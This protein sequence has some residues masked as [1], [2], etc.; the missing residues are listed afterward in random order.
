MGL[1]PR[2]ESTQKAPQKISYSNPNTRGGYRRPRTP[3]AS[4]ALDRPAA[5]KP[6]PFLSPRRA[7]EQEGRA[8]ACLE[9]PWASTA[10]GKDEASCSMNRTFPSGQTARDRLFLYLII[11]L[12]ITSN[13]GR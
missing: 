13:A 12:S 11:S 7:R 8:F 6:G 5:Q 9:R 4:A 1:E 10:R 3:G 2:K